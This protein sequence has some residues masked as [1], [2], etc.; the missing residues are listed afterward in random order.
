MGYFDG[1]G[2]V[3]TDGSTYDVA[4]TLSMPS[5]LIVNSRGASLSVLATIKGFLSFRED[6]QIRAVILN[7]GVP[8]DLCSVEA[9][10]R[11]GTGSA[12]ARLCAEAYG[13]ESGEP[14]S[15]SG[16]ARRD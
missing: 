8:Y 1:L 16:S 9:T 4:R 3:S 15:G 7:Q 14:S 12:S 2:G 10:D 5:V 11:A 13:S 6:S